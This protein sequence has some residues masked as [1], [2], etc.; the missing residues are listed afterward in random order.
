MIATS[1]TARAETPLPTPA[2]H[3]RADV[4]IFD[5]HC[6]FCRAQVARLHAWD[7]GQRLAFVSLHEPLIAEKYPDLSHDQLMREMVIVDRFGQRHAGASA[8]RYLSRRLPW[9]WPLAPL[10]HIP[11]SL[12][13]WQWLYRQIAIRRYRWGRV[14][15]CESGSCEVHF[16]K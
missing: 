11:L 5:G 2:D 1:T 3:P 10:L 14:D 9:M 4:V 12:P 8:V 13:L 16:R 15:D 7:G 6:R